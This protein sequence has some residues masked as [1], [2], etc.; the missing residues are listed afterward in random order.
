[1][2]DTIDSNVWWYVGR[3]KLNNKVLHGIERVHIQ[4]PVDQNILLQQRYLGL[5]HLPW[6][7]KLHLPM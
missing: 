7:P 3:C 1:M 4:S 2:V 6:S 5:C